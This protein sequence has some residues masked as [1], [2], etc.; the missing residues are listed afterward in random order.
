MRFRVLILIVVLGL[1][2]CG[3]NAPAPTPT[4]DPEVR[5][6][7]EV[8]SRECAACHSL[9]PDTV[10][11]GPSLAGVA[12]RAETRVAGMDAREYLETS[13]LDPGAH[14]VDGFP[15]AMPATFGKELTGQELDALVAFLLTLE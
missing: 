7:E 9:S 10:V 1:V 13:I 6:G 8:F 12:T 2:S 11:V 5:E 3:T 4:I 14:V 15:D